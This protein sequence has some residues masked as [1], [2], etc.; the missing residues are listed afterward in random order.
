MDEILR[1][2]EME[3]IIGTLREIS[4]IYLF[5]SLRVAFFLGGGGWVGWGL[6]ELHLRR[7][8]EWKN[9]RKP[10]KAIKYI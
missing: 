10:F 4:F 5:L 9:L 3:L 7:Q 8:L 2:W 6:G 1:F